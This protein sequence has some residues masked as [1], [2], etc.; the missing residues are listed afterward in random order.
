MKKTTILVTIIL[1]IF[2]SISSAGDLS[3]YELD[4]CNWLRVKKLQRDIDYALGSNVRIKDCYK[5]DNRKEYLVKALSK[6]TNEHIGIYVDEY[7]ERL[8]IE[9][10][11]L[12]VL[13]I[14]F[15]DN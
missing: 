9:P 15:K 4:K 12:K 7:N 11:V 5:M 13:D 10:D 8:S 3:F 1:C 14:Y 2:P 6:S